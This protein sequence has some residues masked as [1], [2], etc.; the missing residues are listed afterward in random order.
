MR[1]IWSVSRRRVLWRYAVGST[2][3]GAG[4]DWEYGRRRGGALGAAR[5]FGGDGVSS[6]EEVGKGSLGHEMKK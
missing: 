2:V 4:A 6:L 3:V 5:T 1:R